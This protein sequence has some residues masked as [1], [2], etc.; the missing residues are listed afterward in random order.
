MSCAAEVGKYT[1]DGEDIIGDDTLAAMA[2]QHG[3]QS[4][5]VNKKRTTSKQVPGIDL[6]VNTSALK[7]DN[8]AIKSD[9]RISTPILGAKISEPSVVKTLLQGIAPQKPPLHGRPIAEGTSL[10]GPANDWL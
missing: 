6:G 3:V 4:T 9:K 10:K 2:W 7:G 1:R 8:H 5:T